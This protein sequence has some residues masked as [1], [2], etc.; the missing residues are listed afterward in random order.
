[1]ILVMLVKDFARC[2]QG[3][4]TSALICRQ[5]P[6]KYQACLTSDAKSPR[7]MIGDM[8][9]SMGNDQLFQVAESDQPNERLSQKG[10]QSQGK[11]PGMWTAQDR[12]LKRRRG[13]GSEGCYAR[14][15]YRIY[16][17]YRISNAVVTID[18]DCG[19]DLTPTRISEAG[20]ASWSSST[21]SF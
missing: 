13:V 17:I 20:G 3:A 14:G 12:Q 16:R 21:G 4:H 2:S 7:N 11:G 8:M 10:C 18:S 5:R 6:R 19:P 9:H 1:M 15:I